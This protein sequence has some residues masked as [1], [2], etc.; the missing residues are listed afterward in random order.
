M[1]IVDG[2]QDSPLLD[3]GI[4]AGDTLVSIDGYQVNTL[5]Q[6]PEALWGSGG[7]QIQ[8]QYRDTRGIAHTVTVTPLDGDASDSD[9]LIVD[10]L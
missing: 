1:K 5:D 10:H 7:R 6:L 8:V 2:T 9:P 3:T 4:Q